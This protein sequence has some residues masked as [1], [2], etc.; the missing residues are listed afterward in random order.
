MAEPLDTIPQSIG[1]ELK[2]M[3]W[4]CAWYAANEACL[5]NADAEKDR[6][7]FNQ[8]YEA[9]QAEISRLS[10]SIPAADIKDM[11]LAS[12][13]YTA[14]TRIKHNDDAAKAELAKFEQIA[15]KLQQGGS[16]TA[17]LAAELKWMCWR[18]SWH[19]RL[20]CMLC[21]RARAHSHAFFIKRMG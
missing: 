7:A 3:A 6:E 5:Y 21:L 11:A 8:H 18:A 2:W 13:Q 10:L 4:R 17:Q 19:G 9:A 14:Y 12:S 15:L 20:P 1:S 16:V